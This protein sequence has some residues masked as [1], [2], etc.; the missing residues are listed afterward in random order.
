[1]YNFT[2]NVLVV[3][4]H[5]DIVHLVSYNKIVY[6]IMREVNDNINFISA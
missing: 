2:I 6:K 3:K 4:L 1:M 5:I